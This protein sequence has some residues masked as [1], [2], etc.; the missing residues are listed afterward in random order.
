M[1]IGK[2]AIAIILATI[3][4]I[5]V[6]ATTIMFF[7]LDKPA[8][9]SVDL[10]AYAIQLYAEETMPTTII[11]EILFPSVMANSPNSISNTSV[12]YLFTEETPQTYTLKWGSPD[13]PDGFIIMAYWNLAGD[14]FY[15]WNEN[16]EM[17]VALTTPNSGNSGMRLYFGLETNNASVGNYNF[18]IN[19]LVGITE[20]END[21]IFKVFKITITWTI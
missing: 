11:T 19:I 3:S 12:I 10:N 13:L 1:K 7:L 6:S 8:S 16:V 4:I 20:K 15:Q 2:K 9:I 21:N 18:H 17:D 14:M 5:S